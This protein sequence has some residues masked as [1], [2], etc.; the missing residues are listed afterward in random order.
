MQKKRRYAVA[1]PSRWELALWSSSPDSPNRIT[2]KKNR[3]TPRTWLRSS[4]A[5]WLHLWVPPGL[6]SRSFEGPGAR[7]WS[8]KETG[9]I[10]RHRGGLLDHSKTSAQI[11]KTNHEIMIDLVIADTANQSDLLWY[12]IKVQGLHVPRCR[13]QEWNK[14]LMMIHH[15]CFNPSFNN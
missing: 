15:P 10:F 7:L 3:A 4:A 5:H 8:A 1:F 2:N 6:W 9:K 13:K 12:W 11:Q 14:L